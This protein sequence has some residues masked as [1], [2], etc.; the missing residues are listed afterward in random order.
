MDQWKEKREAAGD[1][2]TQTDDIKPSIDQ[3]TQ[4]EQLNSDAQ[5]H[6]HSNSVDKKGSDRHRQDAHILVVCNRHREKTTD[7]EDTNKE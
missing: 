1:N 3:T 7:I 6:Q 2:K 5:S 4:T